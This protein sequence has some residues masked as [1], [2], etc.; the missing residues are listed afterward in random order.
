M[1]R[2]HSVMFDLCAPMKGC[3][4]AP[5]RHLFMEGDL[6]FKDNVSKVRRSIEQAT[7]TTHRFTQL[8]NFI[9]HFSTRLTQTRYQLYITSINVLFLPSPFDSFFILYFHFRFFDFPTAD[10]WFFDFLALSMSLSSPPFL[11][12]LLP[13]VITTTPQ[14]DVHCFLLTDMLLICKTTAKKGHG[15]LKVSLLV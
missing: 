5:E 12:P 14:I 1:V 10:C 15:T 9:T 13:T 11:L 4:T 7:H 3:V 8:E 2:Q 6:K